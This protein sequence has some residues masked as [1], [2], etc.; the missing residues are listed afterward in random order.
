MKLEELN[1]NPVA[2]VRESTN[3]TVR[4]IKKVCKNIGPRAAGS[5]NENKA[6]DYI[7]ENCAKFADTAEKETFRLSPRAFMAWPWLGAVIE[8]IA[9]ALFILSA[10][11]PEQVAQILPIVSLG[12][13]VCDILLIALEFL[14]YKQILDPFFKKA[15]S[16]NVILTKKPKGEVQ[17]RIIFSGHSLITCPASGLNCGK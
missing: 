4:E 16:S 11:V 5:E 8:F 17:R 3:F 2:K 6:Q 10:F 14:L 15:D 1:L 7:L 12:L 9:I 13:T